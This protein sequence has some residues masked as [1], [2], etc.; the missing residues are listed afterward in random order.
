MGH[1]GITI[2][3][4]RWD[5]GDGTHGQWDMWVMEHVGIIMHRSRWGQGWWGTW[6]MGHIFDI[7]LTT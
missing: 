3:R 2:H 6:A 1:V 4:S 5:R 7:F